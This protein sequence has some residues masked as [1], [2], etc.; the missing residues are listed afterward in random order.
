MTL[1]PS[2]TNSETLT[3]ANDSTPDIRNSWHCGV[4]KC[5][6]GSCVIFCPIGVSGYYCDTDRPNAYCFCTGTA[7][8]SRYDNCHSGLLWDSSINNCN[9]AYNV[10]PEHSCQ[11]GITTTTVTPTN[12]PMDDTEDLPL[13]SYIPV[14]G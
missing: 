8:P 5:D 14:S 11:N 1:P 9:W 6:S 4:D 10:N 3:T 13:G 7:A 12:P 2:T